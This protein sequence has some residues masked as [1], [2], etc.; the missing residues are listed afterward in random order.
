MQRM[1]ACGYTHVPVLKDSRVVGVFS[2]NMVFSCVLDQTIRTF[3]R[4]TRFLDLAAY[5]P[6]S[7]RTKQRFAFVSRA[8]S[9]YVTERL[10]R[11]SFDHGRRL[12][13]LFITEN[14]REEEQILGLLTPWDV[15]GQEYNN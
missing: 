13:M 4:N 9:I 3:S 2:E 5:L 15:L 8:G 14:G 12:D 1:H 6:L 7:A 11:E 10:L